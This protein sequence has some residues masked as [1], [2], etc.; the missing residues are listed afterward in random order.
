MIIDFFINVAAGV[1][2]SV[3][4]WLVFQVLRPYY[5]AWRYQAP[6]LEGRWSLHDSESSETPVVGSVHIRQA[7]ELLSVDVTRVM[8]RSGKSV[9]RSFR[10]KGSIRDGQVLLLYEEPISG[11]FIRG[12]ITLKLSSNLKMLSGFTVYLDR[13]SGE[14]VAYPMT[15]QRQ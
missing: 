9:S 10:A 11:G 2:L 15:Y 14:I 1:F 7:G 5:L 13:D 3:A 8:S 4:A 6:R 12:N